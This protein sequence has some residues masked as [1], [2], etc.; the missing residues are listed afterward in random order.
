MMDWVGS[1][2]KAY[3]PARVLVSVAQGPVR[4]ER[5]VVIFVW[6]WGMGLVGGG[7]D[8]EGKRRVLQL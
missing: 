8:V 6:V 2:M 5:R 7:R 1:G 4:V 3:A